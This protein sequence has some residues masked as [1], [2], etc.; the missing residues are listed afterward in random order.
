MRP[1]APRPWSYEMAVAGESERF[2]GDP[3]C[4]PPLVNCNNPRGRWVRGESTTG[5]LLAKSTPASRH[6]RIVRVAA[7]ERRTHFQSSGSAGTSDGRRKVSSEEKI[8]STWTRSSVVRLSITLTCR[9]I[10]GR[11]PGSD[12]RREYFPGLRRSVKKA[13]CWLESSCETVRPPASSEM[14][15]TVAPICGVPDGSSTMPE[16]VPYPGLAVAALFTA[17]GVTV[18][19]AERETVCLVKRSVAWIAILYLPG[20]KALGPINCS[21]V[22][23]SPFCLRSSPVLTSWET[24]CCP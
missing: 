1:I 4:T 22:T 18:K 23:C 13:P 20:G 15:Q 8:E 16:I 14:S 12:T 11:N 9:S 21:Y 24:V 17:G 3:G 10:A 2:E 19:S 7:E 5:A 6:C